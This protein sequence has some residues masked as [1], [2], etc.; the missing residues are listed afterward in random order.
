MNNGFGSGAGNVGGIG[1]GGVGGISVLFATTFLSIVLFTSTAAAF[2]FISSS[3]VTTAPP[4][5]TNRKRSKDDANNNNKSNNNQIIANTAIR[6]GITVLS[7]N[8]VTILHDDDYRSIEY[9]LNLQSS[10]LSL[11][12]PPISVDISSCIAEH[13]DYENNDNN[14]SQQRDWWEELLLLNESGA[15]A[16]AAGEEGG[17]APAVVCLI[18]SNDEQT[19]QPVP[20]VTSK[21]GKKIRKPMPKSFAGVISKLSTDFR[22]PPNLLANVL[23]FD[24]Y[25]IDNNDE[26]SILSKRSDQITTNLKNLGAKN[27]HDVKQS[28]RS[29]SNSSIKLRQEEKS[30]SQSDSDD[31]SSDIA[32][33]FDS[34]SHDTI[35]RI[36]RMHKLHNKQNSPRSPLDYQEPDISDIEELLISKSGTKLPKL[37]ASQQAARTQ[38]RRR[39]LE[40]KTLVEDTLAEMEVDVDFQR[41]QRAYAELG[42]KKLTL[43]ERKARRRALSG[44][45]K[46]G[47]EEFVLQKQELEEQQLLSPT[48]NEEKLEEEEAKDELHARKI[49][50]ANNLSRK[51]PEILQI[52]IGLYCNQ[53]CSHCHVESS[54]RRKEAMTNEIARRCAHLLASS[55]NVHTLDITGGAPE[56]NPAFRELVKCA[57][58]ARGPDSLTIIDRCNLTVLHEPGQEDLVEFL[59]KHQVNIV[60]SLP[61]YSAKNV[62]KQR[63]AGVFERSISAL[64]ML[65]E[66]GYG[67]PNTNHKIDLVYNPGGAF[68]PPDQTMLESKYKE[69]LLDNF[70]IIF[71][72]LFT[73]TNMPIKRFAD[74]L[75]RKGELTTYMEL[76]VQNFNLGTVDSLMCRNTISVN[77]DGK[78]FDCDFNQQLGFGIGAEKDD[79]TSSTSV[80]A[81]KHLTHDDSGGKSVFD[82]ETLSEL[83]KHDITFDNHCF[84]CTAGEGSS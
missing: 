15:N 66:A 14:P 22:I 31:A 57:R 7:P 77:Y 71:N 70:G 74:F 68:L 1:S 48:N 10:L 43:E 47:F 53:A 60:A 29:K 13:E 54:P 65:N 33:T 2:S 4:P 3:A 23:Q 80:T 41:T 5:S 11:P 37:T 28:K 20:V 62:D 55:P 21:K 19:Q 73:M 56:L 50:A 16:A 79:M 35:A 84:G 17:G 44:V 82:V 76:L 49:K 30:D 72:Q 6:T 83:Q 39:D 52:N 40:G 64:L 42:A 75:L 58:A 24:V 8:V 25:C 12:L 67:N 32:D 27:I 59:V 26:D 18:L 61:C 51:D 78:V 45:V 34:W 46:V 36:T 69:E 38:Y 63:G 81:Q 9:A